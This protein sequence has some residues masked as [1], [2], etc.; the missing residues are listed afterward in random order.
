MQVITYTLGLLLAIV[1]LVSAAPLD[2]PLAGPVDDATPVD[3]NATYPVSVSSSSNSLEKRSTH[4]VLFCKG[5][6]RKNCAPG[7]IPSNTCFAFNGGWDNHVSSIYPGKNM[8]CKIFS[9]RR[10]G[11]WS[12]SIFDSKNT[13][14]PSFQNMA[15]SLECV[16]VVGLNA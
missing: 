5:Q 2:S 15:S 12:I 7:W 3:F 11:G 4:K 9:T 16:P 8:W 1:C 14:L 13:N 10:C 6:N